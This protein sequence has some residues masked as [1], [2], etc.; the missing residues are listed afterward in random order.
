M[1]SWLEF[2]SPVLCAVTTAL[3]GIITA[4]VTHVQRQIRTNHGTSGA[5]ESLDI[6]Q[7]KLD[8]LAASVL[9]LRA[10]QDQLTHRIE[11]CEL[12]LAGKKEKHE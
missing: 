1:T 7:T 4:K 3:G 2:L 11:T 5:G 8:T 9:D 6:I 10:G 12:C